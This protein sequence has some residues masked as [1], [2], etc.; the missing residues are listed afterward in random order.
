MET[1]VTETC[2]NCGQTLDKDSKCKRCDEICSRCENPYREHIVLQ[3]NS[4][5]AFC[6]DILFKSSGEV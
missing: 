6:P 2:F 3:E 4:G 1:E 5:V